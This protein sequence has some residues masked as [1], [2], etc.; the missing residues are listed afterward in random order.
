MYIEYE[1]HKLCPVPKCD[2]LVYVLII[3]AI[4]ASSVTFHY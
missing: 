2:M 1:D 3:N 4:N